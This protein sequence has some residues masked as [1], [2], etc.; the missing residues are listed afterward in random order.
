M[1]PFRSSPNAQQ[2]FGLSVN[3]LSWCTLAMG[4]EK[5]FFTLARTHSRRPWT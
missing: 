3:I 5:H 4:R 1:T 2:Y